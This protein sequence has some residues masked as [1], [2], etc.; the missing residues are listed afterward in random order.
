M[1]YVFSLS[2][3]FFVLSV[4]GGSRSVEK[5]VFSNYIILNESVTRL[6]PTPF[7]GDYTLVCREVL[8]FL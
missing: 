2:Y 6:V 7:L 1:A 5:R 4:G 8:G 3:H